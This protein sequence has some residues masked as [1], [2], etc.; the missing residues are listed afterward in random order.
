M[1]SCFINDKIVDN[2]FNEVSLI[3]PMNKGELNTKYNGVNVNFN[4]LVEECVNREPTQ[5]ID[6][7]IYRYKYKAG[8]V[9]TH[10][11]MY[12]NS[13][14][15]FYN[16][17]KVKCSSSVR[18]NNPQKETNFDSKGQDSLINTNA[19]HIDFSIIN[20][21][22][23][24]T[25]IFDLYDY[26]N[27]DIII[28]KYAH[29]I[30]TTIL[31]LDNNSENNAFIVTNIDSYKYKF[32]LFKSEDSIHLSLPT[33]GNQLTF[34]D[35]KYYGKVKT[36]F[37]KVYTPS[38]VLIVNIFNET[39]LFVKYQSIPYST[40][41]KL[42][43]NRSNKYS[44]DEYV[45]NNDCRN[46]IERSGIPHSTPLQGSQLSNELLIMER[47]TDSNTIEGE[48]KNE[49]VSDEIKIT[50]IQMNTIFEDIDIFSF[51][52]FENLLYKKH[53]VEPVLMHISKFIMMNQVHRETSPNSHIYNILFCIEKCKKT[54]NN[55]IKLYKDVFL[56]LMDTSSN[57]VYNRFTQRFVKIEMYTKLICQWFIHEYEKFNSK[58]SIYIE[59]I[60]PISPFF[61]FSITHI[62]DF[63]VKSYNLMINTSININN[64]IITKYNTNQPTNLSSG[65][66]CLLF[67]SEKTDILFND[68]LI[69]NMNQG[70]MIIYKN[71][72][73][74]IVNNEN[75]VYILSMSFHITLIR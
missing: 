7:N 72:P 33:K 60:I 67:L 40:Q 6:S 59:N 34:N 30:S 74:E 55:K 70:D 23:N 61:I 8:S 3:Y 29:P 63:V 69:Y 1:N 75:S 31:Y 17:N 15:S 68:G 48:L 54:V 46:S 4:P 36:N 71:E 2:I 39:P 9:E 50:T 16:E 27:K 13:I 28:K 21:N 22:N 38:Y 37:N 57:I 66:V 14:L 58:S 47:D 64:C 25:S 49:H 32:K 53:I 43:I 62:S 10:T 42:L 56:S 26:E 18:N 19:L 35:G 44:Q 51:D 45:E 5:D 65:F 20:I 11:E 73:F 52:F 12:V 24:N 41:L